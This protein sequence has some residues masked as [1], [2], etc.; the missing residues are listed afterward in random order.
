MAFFGNKK[1]LELSPRLKFGVGRGF[2]RNRIL[3][4]TSTL[5]LIL[6]IGLG[7][8]AV[9]LI[10]RGNG[11]DSSQNQPQ[12]LG[13]S[14]EKTARDL[15]QVQFVEYQVVKGDT[16]FNISQKFNISWTTLATLN[17][18]KAPFALKPGLVL[19]IPK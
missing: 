6:A 12:V 19:K 5:F 4:I 16:L 14:D 7:I 10:F 9:L 2:S 1:R 3:K 15:D 11:Q 8:N 13:A 17:N 18:L